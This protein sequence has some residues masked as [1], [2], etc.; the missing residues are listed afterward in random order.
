MQSIIESDENLKMFIIFKSSY[1]YKI[2]KLLESLTE[3]EL[4]YIHRN[5]Y[6]PIIYIGY[7]EKN[8]YEGLGFI[9]KNGVIVVH[10]T[11]K[12]GKKNGSTIEYV[13][14]HVSF[15][16]EYVDGK[17]SGFGRLYNVDDKHILTYEGLFQDDK[18]HGKGKYF[19]DDLCYDGYFTKNKLC[20]RAQIYDVI[21]GNCIFDGNFEE[22][23]IQGYG[24]GYVYDNENYLYMEYKGNYE[25]CVWH[26]KGI[27]IFENNIYDGN[28]RKGKL[29]NG[30][31][32][33][34]GNLVYDGDFCKYEYHGYGSLIENDETIYLGT[35]KH[36]LKHGKGV[37]MKW[38]SLDVIF[39]GNFENN[40]MKTVS[41]KSIKDEFEIKKILESNVMIKNSIQKIEVKNI[42]NYMKKKEIPYT[43]K[44]NK[45]KLLEKIIQ[46]DWIDKKAFYQS[47]RPITKIKKEYLIEFIN[48]RHGK[49]MKLKHKN[50]S[51]L[52][53]LIQKNK[54]E[55]VDNY[56]FFGNEIKNPVLGCDG[57]IYDKSSSIELQERNMQP[58]IHNGIKLTEF[59]TYEQV[60]NDLEKKKL[61]ENYL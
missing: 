54:K 49:K 3:K 28:F 27:L 12:N 26:G 39:E 37:L 9:F 56:D 16:G 18:Y 1:G 25:D 5:E 45:K 13:N 21:K 58:T 42:H 52:L 29:I 7:L 32:F 8:R 20:G 23:I 61:F 50:K 17:K 43:K 34:E 47:S 15:Q 53:K 57:I 6:K 31:K 38:D 33:Q 44:Q 22:N 19:C 4:E 48:T 36:G 14:N 2:Q 55:E 10:S 46:F 35:F 51:E 40:H 24:T 59:F 11:F 30:R 41:N 60:S